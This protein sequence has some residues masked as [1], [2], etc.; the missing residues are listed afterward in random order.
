MLD[1]VQQ[2]SLHNEC[3]DTFKK[4]IA[5]K[6]F[7]T[8][9]LFAE[10]R[11]GYEK[12]YLSIYIKE[13]TTRYPILT[14]HSFNEGLLPTSHV[15][16]IESF[17]KSFCDDIFNIINN[18][19]SVKMLILLPEKIPNINNSHSL[20]ILRTLS[21]FRIIWKTNRIQNSFQYD[22]NAKAH[23]ILI[24]THDDNVLRVKDALRISKLHLKSLLTPYYDVFTTLPPSMALTNSRYS[25]FEI[26]ILLKLY[27]GTNSFLKHYDH[28]EYTFL[29]DFLTSS[30]N[31]ARLAEKYNLISIQV[32][33]E[34]IL[35]CFHAFPFTDESH[36]PLFN[37][38]TIIKHNLK[39]TKGWAKQ[40]KLNTSNASSLIN[41]ILQDTYDSPKNARNALLVSS[42]LYNS[43]NDPNVKAIISDKVCSS[44]DFEDLPYWFSNSK[45][46]PIELAICLI[47]SKKPAL[48]SFATGV[49]LQFG[50]KN[51]LIHI[52]SVNQA[53][54]LFEIFNES[55][56]EWMLNSN[57]K[58]VNSILLQ[59]SFNEYLD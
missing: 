26:C 39:E 1:T 13:K 7:K 27:C 29:C 25:S 24:S 4:I 19:F 16:A 2:Q 9:T 6:Q 35:D 56:C 49:I 44:I 22:E 17:L 36:L 48:L 31:K 20:E 37:A 15:N 32:P 14:D 41:T 51:S 50:F 38:E 42:V 18:K 23:S 12:L 45:Q 8:L 59:L 33:N 55:P 58:E 47:T 46:P 54:A 28:T 3:I 52:T 34:L 53:C 5:N 30:A 43:A 40:L 21:W 57:P 10:P 11:I